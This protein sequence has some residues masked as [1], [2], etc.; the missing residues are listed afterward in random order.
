MKK[1]TLIPVMGILALFVISS[2]SL[3]LKTN[4]IKA[5]SEEDSPVL[6]WQASNSS[7]C[8]IPFRYP[9]DWAAANEFPANSLTSNLEEN[10]KIEVCAFFYDKELSKDST[11]GFLYFYRIPNNIKIEDINIGSQY[12]YANLMKQRGLKSP[13]K[14]PGRDKK[15]ADSY[16]TYLNDQPINGYA[17]LGNGF[18]YNFLWP[19]GLG[20][21]SSEKV[22]LIIDSIKIN[23]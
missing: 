4:V 8:N 19:E 12:D 22:R 9:K 10:P 1:E 21:T 20:P 11:K 18:I 6:G 16:I 5:E 15:I 7:K 2:I 13:N 17:I 14:L 23:P 3:Y